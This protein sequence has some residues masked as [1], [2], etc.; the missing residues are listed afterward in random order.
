MTTSE[1]QIK[2]V[3]DYLQTM[4][5]IVRDIA[6]YA[7]VY[8]FDQ[9]ILGLLSKSFSISD[10]ALTLI[11]NNHPEEAYGLCRSLVECGL[12]LRYLTQNED[13]AER[14]SRALKFA[15]FFFKEKQYWIYQAKQWITDVAALADIDRYTTENNIVPDVQPAS[16]HW[17]EQGGFTWRCTNT[18]HPLDGQTYNLDRRKIEYA[19]DYHAT[20]AY[21][22][23]SL[24]AIEYLLPPIRYVYMPLL[25]SL[26]DDEAQAGQKAL[27]ILVRYIY[28]AT[29]Y[30]MFGMEVEKT[31]V[32]DK[33]FSYALSK[34]RP[35]RPRYKPEAVYRRVFD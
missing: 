21:V 18:D 2:I 35:I 17:S 10:A 19:V 27:Y 20:S 32:V 22:H 13:R 33:E 24:E 8:V 14:E 34:L 31:E 26:S 11:E 4:Q 28:L 5:T 29:R 7:R 16:E 12:N 9:V 30:A 23:C 1:D 6:V 25:K 3:R 15:R